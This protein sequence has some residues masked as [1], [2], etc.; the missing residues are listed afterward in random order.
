MFRSGTSTASGRSHLYFSY[1][2]FIHLYRSSNLK[3]SFNNN[4]NLKICMCFGYNPTVNFCHILFRELRHFSACTFRTWTLYTCTGHRIFRTCTFRTWTLYTCTGHRIWK[5]H[6]IIMII[7]RYACALDI[8]LQL[9]FAIFCF[10]NFVIFRPQILRKCIDSRY[11]ESA[12]SHII[13]TN[14]FFLNFVDIF[15]MV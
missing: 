15:S 2:Y 13:F 7:W 12:I 9:I 11:L 14:P 10:V 4:D 6:L 5:S 8:I 1:L 3:I